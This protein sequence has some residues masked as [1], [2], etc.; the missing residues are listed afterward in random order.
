MHRLVAKHGQCFVCMKIRFAILIFFAQAAGNVNRD[1]HGFTLVGKNECI[2]YVFGQLPVKTDAEHGINDEFCIC[3]SFGRIFLYRIG[4]FCTHGSGKCIIAVAEVV[5][6]HAKAVL[7]KVTGDD[8]A[9]AA[10]LAAAA[11]NGGSA[12]RYIC[13]N[14]LRTA[15]AG[16]FHHVGK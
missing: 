12:R 8:I 5:N 9:V 4:H 10:V 2:F 14:I 15:S 3:E 1:A 7:R 6:G 11:K 16:V 13:L